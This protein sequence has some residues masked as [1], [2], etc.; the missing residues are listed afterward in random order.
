MTATQEK[1]IV[2]IGAGLC[3][4][5]L[6]IRL[7]QRG[8][9]VELFEKRDDMRLTEVEAG[10]SI[11]LALSHRG[12]MAL[13]TAGMREQVIKDCIPMHGRLIHSGT[14]EKRFSRYSGRE[15]EYINS[16]SRPGL[17]ISMLEKADS[18]DNLNIH[19]GQKCTSV[20][21]DHA[22]ATFKTRSG[23]ETTI[24]ASL[25]VGTDGAGSAV[26]RSMMARSTRLLFNYS[27]DFLRSGYKELHI[28]PA[29]DGG[30]QIEKNAL[31]IWPRGKFMMIAL[32]NLDGSFTVTLFHPY[33]GEAGFNKLNEPAEVRAFFEKYY[34]DVLPHLPNLEEDYFLNPTAS[35]GT[36]R[37][38]PW[39]TYGKTVIMGDAAHAIVPF[40]GQGMNAALEDV[41]I[42]D[43]LIEEFQ[44]DWP[45]ILAVFSEQRPKDTN[46]IA[47]LALDNF[48]EM[49][50]GVNDPA[51]IKKRQLE[52]ELEDRFPDYYSKY[53][54]VTFRPEL[55][56]AEAMLK[57]RRQDAFLLELCAK[58]EIADLDIE[59]VFKQV[60]H[61]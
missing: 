19:F 5:L 4:T 29:A 55:S 25:L 56:Y 8:Y 38:Y 31:H 39:E 32:P 11:N 42:F 28:P 36:I 48:L 27:Q 52:M 2:I 14:G 51:F 26:R 18:Y 54:L 44:G 37:C 58:H 3:G 50:S 41:R 35:L 60:Q 9:R 12:L 6:G 40:Y 49:Q 10:R 47:D 17:N 45:K 16:V 13:E 59:E 57:G 30:W 1:P 15:E 53:S 61:L 21:L 34:P 22:S 23:E 7:A 20:D 43:E 24:E 33:E 46:A